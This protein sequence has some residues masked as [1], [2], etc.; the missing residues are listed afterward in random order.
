MKATHAHRNRLTM[1]FGAI[2]ALAI[3]LFYAFV[4]AV[5]LVIGHWPTYGNPDPA[6]LPGSLLPFDVAV[7]LLLIAVGVGPVLLIPA[8][9]AAWRQRF[10]WL[11]V[12]IAAYLASW[13]ILVALAY[14]DPGGFFDWFAD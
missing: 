6:Q 8:V 11:L 5:R 13:F 12:P 4:I 7:T 3:L 2:P 14:L 9:A 10:R 1:A